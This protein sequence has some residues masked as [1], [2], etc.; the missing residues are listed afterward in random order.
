MGTAVKNRV[1]R[2]MDTVALRSL[3]LLANVAVVVLVAGEQHQSSDAGWPV[4]PALEH[5]GHLHM[6][7]S[8]A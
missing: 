5:E 3:R 2:P 7:T 1:G 4:P 6:R 8:V